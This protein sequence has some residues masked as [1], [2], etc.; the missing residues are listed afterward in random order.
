[1]LSLFCKTFYKPQ[2]QLLD[3][4]SSKE[5]TFRNKDDNIKKHKARQMGQIG[6]RN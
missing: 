5:I 1:M 2:F 3:V 6:I 4:F